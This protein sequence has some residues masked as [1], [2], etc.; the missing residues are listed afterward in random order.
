M[1]E[2]REVIRESIAGGVSVLML[3]GRAQ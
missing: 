2:R 1:E 3:K